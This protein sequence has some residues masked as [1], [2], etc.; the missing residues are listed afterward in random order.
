MRTQ[1][2]CAIPDCTSKHFGKGWCRKHYERW[3]RHGDPFALLRE[4]TP[5]KRFWRKVVQD[6]RGCLV[7]IGGKSNKDGY[8]CFRED[9]GSIAAAHRW[10]FEQVCPIPEGLELDHLCKNRACVNWAHLEPVTHAENVRRGN[11]G[12][13]FR[14][15]THCPQGHPYDAA[16]T[17]VNDKGYRACRTCVRA[18][19]K[20]WQAQRKVVRHS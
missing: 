11:V 9:T 15:K 5:A 12:S 4:G 2:T 19:T 10:A 3:H 7:W 6:E 14:G 18:R 1:R 13:H 17:Y 8:G 20:A 16:N